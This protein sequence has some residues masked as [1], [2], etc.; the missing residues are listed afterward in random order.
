MRVAVR[1][2]SSGGVRLSRSVASASW[3][4]GWSTRC[5][6]TRRL[7]NKRVWDS[8][9]GIR[10]W[11]SSGRTDR[12]VRRMRR[13]WPFFSCS[14][15][16]VAAV[17]LSRR[18]GAVS[19]VVTGGTVITENAAHQILTPGAVAIDGTDIVDVGA[20]DAIAARYA[21][22]ET[23]DAARPGRHARPRSTRTRTRRWSCSAAWPTTSRCMDWLQKYIFPAEA[24]TVSPELRPHRHAPG[25]ARDDRVGHDD[26]RR[27]VL[28]R[29]GDREGH[30]RGGAARRARRRRSSSFRS[31][32]RRRRPTRWPAPSASSR[33][34]R[35]TA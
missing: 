22:A 9:L 10:D 19:L 35:A 15:S 32:T 12:I 33:T 8:G 34:S 31:P 28:L 25:R 5:T 4:S 18:G 20:P 30:A 17:R 24:K 13:V 2:N 21:A 29:G 26:L 3:T 7:Y 14:R 27:H 23:I 11:G 16:R 1:R 6:G